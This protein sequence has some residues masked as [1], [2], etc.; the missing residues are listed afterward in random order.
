MA[1]SSRLSDERLANQQPHD[2]GNLLISVNLTSPVKRTV[3]LYGGGVNGIC[4]LRSK[5]TYLIFFFQILSSTYCSR[6][7]ASAIS[8]LNFIQCVKLHDLVMDTAYNFQ[9][10]LIV[11]SKV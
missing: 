7:E 2:S 1:G 9:F 10:L 6:P 3:I 8:K 5:G 4:H 11:I